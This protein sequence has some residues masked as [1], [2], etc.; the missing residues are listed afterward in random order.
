[1]STCTTINP[2]HTR[3]NLIQAYPEARGVDN[4]DHLLT[5]LKIQIKLYNQNGPYKVAS[6]DSSDTIEVYVYD[7]V[8]GTADI[9]TNGLVERDFKYWSR[10]YPEWRHDINSH[11][12][13]Y[14]GRQL[15]VYLPGDK[16]TRYY[17][18]KVK[19]MRRHVIQIQKHHR[20]IHQDGTLSSWKYKPTNDKK[21]SPSSFTFCILGIKYSTQVTKLLLSIMEEDA[22]FDY[23]I[24]R[25]GK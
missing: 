19:N 23:R 9:M 6:M 3:T 12:L 20:I 16:K 22:G 17:T 25:R 2:K 10:V 8:F 5:R 7:D 24:V 21:S 1:M 11:E 13:T 14:G 15:F 18:R 4:I